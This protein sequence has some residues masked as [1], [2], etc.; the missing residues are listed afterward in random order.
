M[1]VYTRT[2]VC[3]MFEY[4]VTKLYDSILHMGIIVLKRCV[5]VCSVCANYVVMLII[6]Y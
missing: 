6:E 2:C 1:Y 3:G 4:S 5:C